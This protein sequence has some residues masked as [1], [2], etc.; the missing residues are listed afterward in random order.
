[1]AD[2]AIWVKNFKTVRGS[3]LMLVQK[4]TE[5]KKAAYI[6]TSFMG[7]LCSTPIYCLWQ[8]T[9]LYPTFA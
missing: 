9:V 7:Y 5:L 8:L 4:M 3:T 2:T 6:V 1:M